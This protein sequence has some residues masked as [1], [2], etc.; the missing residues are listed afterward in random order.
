MPV[1]SRRAWL[2]PV[3]AVP[4]AMSG[5][6]ASSA[7]AAAPSFAPKGTNVSLA[8]RVGII[9]FV[10]TGLHARATTTISAQMQLNVT[11][12]CTSGHGRATSTGSGGSTSARSFVASATG[13]ASGTWAVELPRVDVRASGTSCPTT[14]TKALVVVLRDTR[15]GA[16][17]TLHARSG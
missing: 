7:L 9:R 12:T 17:I 15:T 3:I 5:V 10:E 14:T 8:G 4:V 11:A 16:S 2:V 13:Q 6:L 1:H